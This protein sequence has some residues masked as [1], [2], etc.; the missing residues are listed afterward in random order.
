MTALTPVLAR[1][2]L[3][4]LSGALVSYGFLGHADAETLMMDPDV[5]LVVGAVIGAT[6]EGFYAIAKRFGWAT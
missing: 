1:I 2:I 3:R 6:V 5:A 4:Y